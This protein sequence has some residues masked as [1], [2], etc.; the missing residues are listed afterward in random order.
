MDVEQLRGGVVLVVGRRLLGWRVAVRRA[1][2]VAVLVLAAAVVAGVEGVVAVAVEVTK[3]SEWSFTG[4]SRR[5]S[6]KRD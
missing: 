5:N 1:A 6:H 3:G 2:V 4:R